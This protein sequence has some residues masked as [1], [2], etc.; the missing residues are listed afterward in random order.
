MKLL[1]NYECCEIVSCTSSRVKTF[2]TVLR[3]NPVFFKPTAS[4]N[5][6]IQKAKFEAGCS[7]KVERDPALVNQ[8]HLFHFFVTAN[9]PVII[10]TINFK[11]ENVL[12]TKLWKTY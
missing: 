8:D 10:K 11:L 6:E 3:K 7:S 12:F 5:I 1:I 2:F 4:I 9:K